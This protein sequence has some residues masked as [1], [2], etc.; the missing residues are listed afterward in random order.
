MPKTEPVP[1]TNV[2]R[3]RSAGVMRPA[4]VSTASVVVATT[5]P[6]CTAISS[7]RRS[8]VSANTP[9]TMPNRTSG[10]MSAVWTSET[11]MAAWAAW[12]RNHWAPTPCI[13]LPT[14]LTIEASHNQ[15]KTVDRNGA[16]VDEV[17]RPSDFMPESSHRHLPPPPDV[18]LLQT[19]RRWRVWR[20]DPES[21]VFQSSLAP[22]AAKGVW[23]R[24]A[25][26]PL[27][28]PSKWHPT[29]SASRRRTRARKR[30]GA[31]PE[32]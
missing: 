15:R 4:I 18:R 20:A 3:R 8:R 27:G 29:S 9:P 30:F 5:R 23:A 26:Q 17:A 11:R 24:K 2:N 6:A 25:V 13:Q 16:H 22:G 31:D 14:L 10:S 19:S 12:T 1:I 21:E 7:R 32:S 28:S